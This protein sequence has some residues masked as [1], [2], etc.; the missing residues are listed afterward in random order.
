MQYSAIDLHVHSRY[1]G[2]ADDWLLGQLGVQE[3]YTKPSEVYEIAKRKGMD[4]VTLT[5]HDTI[6][7]ALELAVV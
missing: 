2:M 4:F 5:D 6:D 7:G 3:C 1:S